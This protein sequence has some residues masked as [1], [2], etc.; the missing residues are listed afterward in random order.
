VGGDC[1]THVDSPSHFIAGART[2]SDLQLGELIAP[3]IIVDVEAQCADNAD[4]EL[5]V[6]DLLR[7]EAKHGRI[8]DRG[9]VCMRTGWSRRFC[10]V[11]RYRNTNEQT[12][13]MH[14]P[15][16]SRAAA[17]F[18]TTER[19]IVGVGIDTLSLD[20]GISQTFD[21]HQVM[22]AHDKYQ[23]ENLMLDGICESGAVIAV[24]PLRVK[25]APEMMARVVA[26]VPR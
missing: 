1:G 15:G 22:F 6:E 19:N 9:L 21:C 17:E 8:P 14:F 10:D 7:W 12:K 11:T 2:I 20:A 3:L 4:Y 25:Q 18:L 16:F 24:L 13:Q 26:F 23:V 5:N